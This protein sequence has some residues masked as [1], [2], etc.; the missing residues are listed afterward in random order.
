M[1]KIPFK[2]A[3]CRV[4]MDYFLKGSVLKGTVHS[5]CTAARS[6][7]TVESGAPPDAVA[8]LI[9]NAKQGCFAENMIQTAVP[10]EST[11]E[12]NGKAGSL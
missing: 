1:M 8:A 2:K 3:S 5:G 4:E 12:L 11:V 7:F 9:R 6:H 10:L